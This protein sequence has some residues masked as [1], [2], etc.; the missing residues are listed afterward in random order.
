MAIAHLITLEEAARRLGIRPQTLLR[1][2]RSG[3]IG[4][5]L[6]RFGD[7]LLVEAPGQIEGKTNGNLLVMVAEGEV[8]K[9]ISQ[10]EAARKYGL[11]QSLI[12]RWIHQGLIR[13][14]RKGGRGRPYEIVEEDVAR[15]AAIYHEVAAKEKHGFKG[16]HIRSILRRMEMEQKSKSE[17]ER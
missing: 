16:K 7:M 2:A 11:H 17:S 10:V 15:L 13:V 1:Y 9:G 8:A 3:K 14:I 12:S 4:V 6:F 5:K